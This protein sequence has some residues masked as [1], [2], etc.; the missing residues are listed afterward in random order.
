MFCGFSCRN[1]LIVSCRSFM[2][3]RICRRRTRLTEFYQLQETN[4]YMLIRKVLCFSSRISRYTL[5][6]WHS[7]VL[8]GISIIRNLL[9]YLGEYFKTSDHLLAKTLLIFYRHVNYYHVANLLQNPPPKFM[10]KTKTRILQPAG[11][12]TRFDWRYLKTAGFFLIKRI[13]C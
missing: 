11:V 13:Y 2:T 8:L 1:L 3:S 10:S 5:N 7:C 6:Q 9:A 4:K 12:K